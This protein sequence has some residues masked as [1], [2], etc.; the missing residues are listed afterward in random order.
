MPLR[1]SKWRKCSSGDSFLGSGVGEVA[2]ASVWAEPDGFVSR[3]DGVG[4]LPVSG[5]LLIDDAFLLVS[6]QAGFFVGDEV[7][8]EC[9]GGSADGVFGV[10]SGECDGV[11]GGF[12]WFWEGDF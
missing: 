10:A 9:G 4:F 11:W 7:A 12:G 2:T 8:Q 5:G 3:E 1:A 6:D